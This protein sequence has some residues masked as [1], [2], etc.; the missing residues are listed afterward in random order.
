M[1]GERRQAWQQAAAL[2]AVCLL[3]WGVSYGL[4]DLWGSDE[5]RYSRI[6]RELLDSD[7][8]FRLTL[9]GAPYDEKPPL[10]FWMMAAAESLDAGEVS[11]WS[12]RFPSVLCALAT[13]LLTWSLGRRL[14]SP[15]AGLWA[16]LV[17]ATTPLFLRE[18]PTARL[19]MIYAAWT[20]LAFWAWLEADPTRPMIRARVALFWLALL[21]AFFTKGPVALLIVAFVLGWEIWRRRAWRPLLRTHPLAGGLVL[22]ACIGLWFWIE[23]RTHGEAFVAGQ[24]REQTLERFFA[25]SHEKPVYYYLLRLPLDILFPWSLFVVAALLRLGREG[26][27]ERSA[28]R[29]VLVWAFLPLVFFSLAAGKRQM[30]L[31]PLLPAY[32]LLTGWYLDRVFL[33]LPRLR[34]TALGLAGLWMLA[35]LGAAAA[36]LL[37]AQRLPAPFSAWQTALA[38]LLSALLA[39]A[40]FRLWRSDHGGLSLARSLFVGLLLL[41]MGQHLLLNPALNPRKS[42]H[43]FADR[44]EDLLTA[45]DL[46]PRVGAIGDGAKV[47]YHAYGDYELLRLPED[48][49]ALAVADLPDLP[50]LLVV[51]EKEWRRLAPEAVLRGYRVLEEW[52]VSSERL[53]VLVRG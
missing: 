13:V 12:V 9:Y 17:L 5:A 7:S 4:W 48:P 21:C 18:A 16:G 29:P 27:A 33:H 45:R 50:D 25:G 26:E 8:P 10:G 38:L 2:F 1:P 14:F 22:L 31:L 20:T 24:I 43:A 11:P 37:A 40:G 51:R 53:L 32:A 6:A 44:L 39:A 30:Y 28:L 3:L 36:T 15:R 41:G 34:W 35:G 23:G 19:D 49:S 42:A 52:M 47:E 46:P